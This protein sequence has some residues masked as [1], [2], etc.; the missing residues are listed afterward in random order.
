MSYLCVP[1]LCYTTSKV[2]GIY[3]INADS[4]QYDHQ[5]KINLDIL[6]LHH[7]DSLRGKKSATLP[8]SESSHQTQVTQ[9]HTQTIFKHILR[10]V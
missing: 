8:D 10:N 5:I 3:W 6:Q 7:S 9:S 4:C 1:C 2:P